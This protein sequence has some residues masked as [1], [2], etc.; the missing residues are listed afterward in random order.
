MITD[1]FSKLLLTPTYPTKWISS[2]HC[3]TIGSIRVLCVL[4]SLFSFTLMAANSKKNLN[5]H[6]IDGE[7]VEVE[8]SEYIVDGCDPES[9]ECTQQG[10]WHFSLDV[11]L[12]LRTNPLNKRKS[13]PLIFIPSWSYYGKRFFIQNLEFGYTLFESDTSQFNVIAT[14]SYDSVFFNRWDPGNFLVDIGGA[15]GIQSTPNQQDD[16]TEINPDELSS[17][18]FSYLGGVEWSKQFEKGLLQVSVLS[19]ITNRHNGSEVRAAY[20]YHTHNY[21]YAT[22]GF[23]WKDKNL[24]DY[25][26]GIDAEEIVDD[27]GLYHPS[28]SL[29]PFVRLSVKTNDDPN[30]WRLSFEYQKLSKQISNSPL[31]KDNHV[32]TFFVGRRFSWD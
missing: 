18:Q 22:I 12:G 24:T 26:Y 14:P 5:E 15:S 13:I 2:S 19:D 20:Q 29:N 16:L 3:P 1:L 32:V 23:T 8:Y 4:T 10:N 28:A 30:G 9:A 11:G 31:V 17:R 27:R 6:M 21:F 7:L 25:Y